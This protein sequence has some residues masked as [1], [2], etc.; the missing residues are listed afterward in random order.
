[1]Y[2]PTDMAYA[3]TLTSWFYSVYLHTPEPYNNSDHPLRLKISI[4]LDSGASFSLLN[5]PTY[6]PIAKCLNII[7]NDKTNHTLKTLT[8]A[9]QTEVPILHYVTT[10][11]IS[12]EQNS[13][14]FKIPFAVAVIKYNIHDASFFEEYI[15]NIK[16]QDCSLQ[17]KHRSENQQNTIILTSLLS[18]Y[19]PLYS[20][21]YRIN[22]STQMCS[23]QNSS[24]SAHFPI[25]NY[26]NLHF[27]TTPK[28][29]FFPTIPHTFFASKFCTTF[30]F[31]EVFTDDK[32]AICSTVTQNSTNHIVTLLKGHIGYIEVPPTNE[33][34]KCY[35]FTDIK[36]LIQKM[37]GLHKILLLQ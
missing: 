35:Q 14:Q 34:P 28:N 13:R 30:I 23:K 10:L 26:Y 18:K 29:Q 33:K 8:V 15:Q 21:I 31:I 4:L 24:K 1:M 25:K 5:C 17:F 16:N 2:H 27:A 11:I 22:S 37:I 12:I 7:C 36:T 9:N 6:L 20:Y 32:H 19:Y 3:L